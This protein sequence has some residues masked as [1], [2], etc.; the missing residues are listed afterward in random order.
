MLDENLIKNSLKTSFFGK[1]LYVFPEIGSTNSYARELVK[2]GAPEG[3][4][5]LADYQSNGKGRLGRHWQSS[6]GAN[7]LMSLILRPKINI[8][9]I[10][11]ITLATSDI[12]ISALEKSIKK[13][14]LAKIK[15]KVKWPN[16]IMVDGKKIAG[17]LCESSVREKAVEYVVV[18]LGINVN[19]DISQ[20][21]EDIRSK[22]T[23]ISAE[24]ARHF[25]RETLIAQ[26]LLKYEQNYI[27]FERT[28]YD[29]G[30][31]NWKKRCDQ[32][33]N[34]YIIKT[35]VS[36]ELGQVIDIDNNGVLVYQTQEGKIKKLIAGDIKYE[37]GIN[38]IDG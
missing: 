23:S 10:R 34:S 13:E 27:H 37:S 9:A 33:G 4:V 8:E 7:I 3:T 31:N 1:Y 14:G 16:D 18:G 11:C 29:Q 25:Q 21:S 12:L 30:I 36:E 17:V 20:L 19:Q 24:T 5:V 38:G 22:T 15:F 26:L 32:I 2:Q 28:N 35:P 6:K